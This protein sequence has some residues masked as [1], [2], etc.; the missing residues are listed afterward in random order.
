MPPNNSASW[1]PRPRQLTMCSSKC[2]A[3]QAAARA[4]VQG[5]T[6]AARGHRRR[7]HRGRRRVGWNLLP[8]WATAALASSA[9]ID[10][11]VATLQ[12]AARLGRDMSVLPQYATVWRALKAWTA[13]ARGD[14]VAARRLGRRGGH[15]HNRLSPVGGAVGARPGRRS[16]KATRNKANAT[17]M[18]RSRVPPKSRLT[19]PFPTS[20]NASPVWLAR[21]GSHREA[22]RL[23]GA[24]HAIQ[25]RRGASPVSRS[26]TR[27]TKLASRR[28]E[29]H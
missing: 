15:G 2:V 10:G 26:G 24:A 11:D 25:E 18:T 27:A 29:P 17:P 7:G 21:A 28:C 1:S 19:C 13:V 3:S 23:F 8:P 4:G 14:L 5:D 22:A 12:D 9:Q 20:S 16:R 6:A